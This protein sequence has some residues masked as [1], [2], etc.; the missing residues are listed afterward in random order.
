MRGMGGLALLVGAY[1]SHPVWLSGALT[2]A[3][4]FMLFEA[5]FGWCVLRALRGKQS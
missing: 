4:V 5:L 1:L 3:G 2:G